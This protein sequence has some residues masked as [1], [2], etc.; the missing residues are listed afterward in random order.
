MY[1]KDNDMPDRSIKPGYIDDITNPYNMVPIPYTE[2]PRGRNKSVKEGY[3]YGLGP[4]GMPFVIPPNR[5][6]PMPTHPINRHKKNV[7]TQPITFDSFAD[8]GLDP[9][10]SLAFSN[11]TGGN[12]L[13]DRLQAGL[14][15]ISMPDMSGSPS[16][17]RD[18]IRKAH[19]K[20]MS[21]EPT[22]A[23]SMQ[24]PNAIDQQE[25]ANVQRER[26]LQKAGVTRKSI[27]KKKPDGTEVREDNF[28][29][30]DGSEVTIKNVTENPYQEQYLELLKQGMEQRNDAINLQP[31]AQVVD[32]WT[33]SNFTPQFQ[34]PNKARQAELANRIRYAGAMAAEGQKPI[35]AAI[36]AKRFREQMNLKEKELGIRALAARNKNKNKEEVS[37]IVN[38]VKFEDKKIDYQDLSDTFNRRG[39]KERVM[40]GLSK[41]R[42]LKEHLASANIKILPEWDIPLKNIAIQ[43]GTDATLD[44]LAMFEALVRHELKTNS[45]DYVKDRAQK[46]A[47]YIDHTMSQ[48]NA[49]YNQLEQ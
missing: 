48:I 21:M 14:S 27:I 45:Y 43:G 26:L 34:D 17:M 9:T 23:M 36:Q 47:T 28:R 2:P 12:S 42:G 15:N 37:K 13:R 31:I 20:A 24:S 5:E 33:G 18:R 49:Y 10:G 25:F 44:K 8:L 32:T 3:R 19:A 40:Y 35:D 41:D 7:Q 46:M 38:Q 6:D 22:N 1:G 30:E 16:S 39:I 29:T 11:N 4:D